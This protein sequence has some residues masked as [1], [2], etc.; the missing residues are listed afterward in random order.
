[1]Q[2]SASRG[3]LSPSRFRGVRTRWSVP[4]WRVSRCSAGSLWHTG[5]NFALDAA[6]VSGTYSFEG[7]TYRVTGGNDD[8]HNLNYRNVTVTTT[9]GTL[10][11]SSGGPATPAHPRP[12]RRWAFLSRPILPHS[13]AVCDR[14]RS[15]PWTPGRAATGPTRSPTCKASPSRGTRPPV[16]GHKKPVLHPKPQSGTACERL[17]RSRHLTPGL[18]LV[19]DTVEHSDHY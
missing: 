10:R 6:P 17:S 14:Q 12:R 4:S 5:T 19:Y 3:P 1:M 18:P 13:K 7:H 16:R 15:S 8:V 9:I 11:F 2:A